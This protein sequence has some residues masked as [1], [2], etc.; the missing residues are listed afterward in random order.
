M[1]RTCVCVF[2]YV[3]V[4]ECVYMYMCVGVFARE[5]WAPDCDHFPTQKRFTPLM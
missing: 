5:I 2:M 3:C 4:R 1:R